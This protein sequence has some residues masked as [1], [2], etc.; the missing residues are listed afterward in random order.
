MKNYKGNM[1]LIELVIAI[2]FFSLSQV[3]IV[4]VFAAAQQKA[5]DSRALHAALMAAEDVAERLSREDE[6]E[7]ALLGMGFMDKD[8]GF[9]L[10]GGAGFDLYVSVT[11]TRGGAGELISAT[12]SARR[13]D[14]ELL[15][16]PCAYY[17][18]EEAR[19]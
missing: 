18:A 14:V 15:A 13:K 17:V 1:L 11:R 16:L 8:G 9:V 5:S 10:S 12:V 7:A 19:P 4:Q 2:L 6:P 3:A